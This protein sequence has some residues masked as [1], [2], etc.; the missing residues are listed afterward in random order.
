MPRKKSPAPFQKSSKLV[1]FVGVSD[2]GKSKAFYRDALGLTLKAEDG[3][4][5]EFDVFGTELRVTLVGKVKPAGYTV[6]GW[7]VADI[8]M[9]IRR[10]SDRGV[11]FERYEGMGQDADAVWTAPS[12]TKVAWFRDPD[13]NTLSLSEHPRRRRAPLARRGRGV[14]R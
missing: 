9:T 14:R 6:L 8:R 10:L 5:L 11:V 3:F 2:A 7:S 1:A 13:G 12:G 4:A